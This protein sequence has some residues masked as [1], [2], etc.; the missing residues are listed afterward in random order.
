[1]TNAPNGGLGAF[2]AH[3]PKDI[4]AAPGVG[5]FPAYRPLTYLVKLVCSRRIVRVADD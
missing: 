4:R 2:A 5:A 3:V 1:M